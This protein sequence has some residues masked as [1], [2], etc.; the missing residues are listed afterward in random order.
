MDKVHE[1]QVRAR[2]CRERAEKAIAETIRQQYSELADVWDRLARE[3]LQYFVA[4]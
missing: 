4:E 2:E 1:F 3:R